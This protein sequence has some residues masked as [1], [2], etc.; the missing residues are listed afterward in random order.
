MH[1]YLFFYLLGGMT[2][3]P[4]TLA[5]TIFVLW[6]RLPKLDPSQPRQTDLPAPQVLQEHA[7]KLLSTSN[8]SATATGASTGVET[9]GSVRRRKSPT[10]ASTRSDQHFRVQS[11]SSST[12]P[13]LSGSSSGNAASSG[14]RKSDH[15]EDMDGDDGDTSDSCENGQDDDDDDNTL[16]NKGGAGIATTLASREPE[17]L[18][19]SD[20]NLNKEGYVRMTRVPRLGPAAES[21]SDYMSNMLF[22]PKNARPKDSYYAVLRYDTLFLYESDQQ[23]D[24]KS[25]VPMN[26]YEVKIF[27]KNLPDNEVFN[28]EHPI[29]IKRRTDTPASTNVQDNDRD[30]YYIFI[31]TPVVKEDWYLALLY[32]SKL[33]KP[34]TKHIVQDKAQ[35]NTEAIQNHI[36]T[37][38]SDKYHE[39]TRWFNSFLGRIFLGVYKTKK[40]QE[41]F[42]QKI[43]RKTLKL[44]RPSF[45]G[46]IKVRSFEV[47]H[48]IPYITR[49]RLHELALNGELTSEF[50][51]SYRGGV[52]VEIEVDVGVGL[53]TLKPVKVTIVLA[54]L[55]KSISGMMTLKIK[56]P[57]TNRFWIGFQ[58]P[59]LMD[60]VIEPVVADKAIKLS[61]VLSAIEAKIREAMIEAIVLPNMDDYP[62]FDSHGTGGIFEGDEE[63][64]SEAVDDSDAE[65]IKA[66]KSNGGKAV[67]MRRGSESS[68]GSEYTPPTLVGTDRMPSWSST[69]TDS[70]V[71]PE[72]VPLA[73]T[74]PPSIAS[75]TSA[76]VYQ[77]SNNN[78]S[79]TSV[80]TAASSPIGSTM[81]RLRKLT[82]AHFHPRSTEALVDSV[83]LNTKPTVATSI[84]TA[85]RTSPT[86][87]THSSVSNSNS[88]NGSTGSKQQSV[89]PK[90]SALNE[91]ADSQSSRI[92]GSSSSN[93]PS[94]KASTNSLRC[95]ASLESPMS[96][97]SE[98]SGHSS[99]DMT[100]PTGCGPVYQSMKSP[101]EVESKKAGLLQRDRRAEFDISP[102][103]V[104]TTARKGDTTGVNGTNN[105]ARRE[106]EVEHENSSIQGGMSSSQ[107]HVG[108][109]GILDGHSRSRVGSVSGATMAVQGNLTSSF[110]S[111]KK[112]VKGPYHHR[113]NDSNGVNNSNNNNSNNRSNNNS[114]NNNTTTSSSDGND[115]GQGFK[116]GSQSNGNN[117][118]MMDHGRKSS[119]DSLMSRRLKADMFVKKLANS[120]NGNSSN[121]NSNS[122][123]CGEEDQEDNNDNSGGNGGHNGTAKMIGSLLG[124][125]RRGS[126]PINNRSE[127]TSVPSA[128]QGP[129][130]DPLGQ[131]DQ[132]EMQQDQGLPRRTLERSK[133]SAASISRPSKKNMDFHILGRPFESTSSTSSTETS[134]Q[135]SSTSTITPS[136]P[137]RAA[138]RTPSATLSFA[139]TSSTGSSGSGSSKAAYLQQKSQA[140]Y[141]A[142]KAWVKRSL[143]DRRLS[144]DD[145]LLAGKMRL[146]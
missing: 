126:L 105:Q 131:S 129:M 48:S 56:R 60:I 62:F 69:G 132:Q 124:H 9:T 50:H 58:E 27:P 46:E 93:G 136:L 45:L 87:T 120:I 23:R 19:Q 108:I 107:A 116:T 142:T 145:P 134:S 77:Q 76:S 73:T 111:D 40:I 49:T 21:I 26:L 65:S 38:H 5:I 61:M 128:K 44:K 4:L 2:F 14:R 96:D 83:K 82:Q 10:K 121:N 123:S 29:Q 71:D 6:I 99:E 43:T 89:I 80:A 16:M 143:E 138:L 109:A 20:P 17:V 34:G 64:S 53:A 112:N 35:F 141:G 68:F 97:G 54:V 3:I 37:I 25:V 41:I 118:K 72:S 139:S 30:E 92:F 11:V 122:G 100:T 15:E 36:R 133:S 18:M 22:Q 78:G 1:P 51:L 81:A 59:P 57:P 146:D 55:V 7:D 140:A 137:M 135:L 114:N 70:D 84:A 119:S 88:G 32:A 28:K 130:K 113:R 91:S 102:K 117:S 101:D 144:E 66:G 74:P 52:R 13:V 103:T 31:H 106:D 104:S 127:S 94:K 8:G 79:N 98:S 39:H 86:G 63:I 90:L 85:K 115:G 110:T 33:R 24:C 67:K 12:S 125:R 75:V 42:I 47:G 95:L